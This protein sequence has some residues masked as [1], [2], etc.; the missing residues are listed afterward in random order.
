MEVKL[1]W[2]FRLFSKGIIIKENKR[3]IFD[4]G[5]EKRNYFILLVVI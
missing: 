5:E 3:I 2:D 1:Y 4:D